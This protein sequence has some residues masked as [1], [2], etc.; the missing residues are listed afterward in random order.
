MTR[1]PVSPDS[2]LMLS[3]QAA[4]RTTATYTQRPK[5]SVIG[6]LYRRS[7]RTVAGFDCSARDRFARFSLLVLVQDERV[8]DE[9]LLAVEMS[10]QLGIF[11]SPGQVLLHDEL[12]HDVLRLCPGR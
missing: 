9:G 11:Q 10:R 3:P 5:R 1:M 12:E 2:G 7:G 6:P 4:S 8:L